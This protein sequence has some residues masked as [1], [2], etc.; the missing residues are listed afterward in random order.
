LFVASYDTICCRF[1]CSSIGLCKIKSRVHDT[2][3]RVWIDVDLLVYMVGTYLSFIDISY[4]VLLEA[5]VDVMVHAF[6]LWIGI[7]IGTYG[8]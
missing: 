3:P 5:Y 6:L 2:N 4:D 1:K 8:W 7:N